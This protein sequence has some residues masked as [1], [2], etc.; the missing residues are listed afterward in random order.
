[1]RFE[2]VCFF[3]AFSFF[4]ICIFPLKD[5]FFPEWLHLAATGLGVSGITFLMLGWYEMWS[6][7]WWLSIIGLGIGIFLLVT[8][9]AA[10]VPWQ[11]GHGEFMI[12]LCGLAFF[13]DIKEK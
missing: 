13:E 9:F 2:H 12:M 11:V 10:K 6:R 7:G 5:S 1:M 8:A 4:A 3:S